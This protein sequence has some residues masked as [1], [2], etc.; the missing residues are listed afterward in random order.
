MKPFLAGIILAAGLAALAAA[1]LNGEVQRTAEEH[2]Q[3]ESV[4]L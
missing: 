1:V 2:Y 3:T 4:R